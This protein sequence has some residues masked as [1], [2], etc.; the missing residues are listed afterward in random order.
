MNDYYPEGQPLPY[1]ATKYFDSYDDIDKA[2]C[3]AFTWNPDPARYPS[4]EPMKQYECAL[5]HGFNHNLIKIFRKFYF[6][7]ELTT[8]GNIHIH[9]MYIIKDPYKYYNVFLPRL[10][11]L[12]LV[13][14]K[15]V[16]KFDRWK[17]YLL[18]DLDIMS[19]VLDVSRIPF[20]IHEQSWSYDSQFFK[21]DSNKR[22]L[23]V[24]PVKRTKA[25]VK[26]KIT[27]FFKEGPIEVNHVDTGIKYDPLITKLLEFETSLKERI[28]LG[29]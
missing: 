15:T 10:K 12:G 13:L 11:K 7:P 28:A 4:Y 18:E 8:N 23:K 14:L 1:S 3:I 9:G 29:L 19:N 5:R 2:N 24:L 25:D 26:K 16:F 22:L 17:E 27:D 6:T 20:P 21:Q